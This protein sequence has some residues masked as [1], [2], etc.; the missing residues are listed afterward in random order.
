MSDTL[1]NILNQ[2]KPIF[3][4]TDEILT[5]WTEEGNLQF[6]DLLSRVALKMELSAK[7]IKEIDPI[8][9]FY[10]RRN[11]D[12]IVTRGAYGG[13][14]RA[15]DIEKNKS[16]KLLKENIKKQMQDQINAKISNINLEEIN[17]DFEE[18]SEEPSDS[19]G[20]L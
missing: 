12:F 20:C 5:S 16:N 7:Q 6:P 9:R 10:V 3:E 11:P 15:A 2:I 17:L 13:I 1:L 8:I 14:K 18:E 4:V 19:E